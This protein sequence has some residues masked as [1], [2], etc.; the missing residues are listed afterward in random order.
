MTYP[1]K[2]TR[3]GTKNHGNARIYSKFWPNLKIRPD[4]S[5]DWLLREN[6]EELAQQIR[7]YWGKRGRNVKVWLEALP[8][9][10]KEAMEWAVRSNLRVSP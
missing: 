7:N 10:P 3:A 8:R 2:S 9:R 6:A 5:K 1:I 4:P